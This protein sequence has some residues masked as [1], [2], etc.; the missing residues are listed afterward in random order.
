MIDVSPLNAIHGDDIPADLQDALKILENRLSEQ[1][2]HVKSVTVLSN[3]SIDYDRTTHVQH[4]L[5]Q[6]APPILQGVVVSVNPEYT[7]SLA[8][9]IW[10]HP[11]IGK[12]RS[13]FDLEKSLNN[14]DLNKIKEVDHLEGKY[15]KESP[16]LM[17]PFNCDVG[18][19]NATAMD[20]MGITTTEKKLVVNV[21]LES[22]TYP[23]WV[24]YLTTNETIGNVYKNWTSMDMGNGKTLVETSAFARE[25]VAKSLI[26]AEI[27]SCYSDEVNALYTDGTNIYFANHAV[28]T[29][30]EEGAQLLVHNSALSGY[31]MYSTK[32]EELFVPSNVGIAS[33]TFEWGNMNASQRARI[34]KD[35]VWEGDEAF[36]TYVL[37]PP[38]LLSGKKKAFEQVYGLYDGNR[39]TMQKAKFSSQ[40]VRDFLDLSQLQKL[41]PTAEVVQDLGV[42]GR[43]GED[44]E[45][46]MSLDYEPFS[47]LIKKFEQLQTEH[48][49]FKLFNEKIVKNGY[50]QVPRD[51]LKK[52]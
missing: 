25:T 13:M 33:K 50:I 34:F 49:D 1:P 16:L 40:P 26:G 19:Y 17:S 41:T 2:G 18:E 21:S 27:P 4:T 3:C 9:A 47:K 31:E 23:L 30:K 12:G 45:V 52:L 36:N 7:L 29:P 5:G 20:D 11:E 10:F 28:K 43:F 15:D 37:R 14:D 42:A 38:G 51:I 46:K 44:L 35:C 24:Q 39:F 22:L 6:E 8:D 48:P 32:T